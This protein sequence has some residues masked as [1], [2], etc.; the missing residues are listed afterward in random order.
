MSSNGRFFV[1][2]LASGK[3][4]T[5]YTGVTGNLIGRAYTHR[6]DL[7]D[8]FTHRYSVHDLVY[9]E[10]FEDPISAITREKRIKK[11]NRDWKVRLIEESNPQW[12]DRFHDI[13]GWL[14]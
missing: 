1:Y 9:F 12:L 4:G 6:N 14:D 5:L 13:A 11:W 7:L 3:N 8:S 10:Q 2:I